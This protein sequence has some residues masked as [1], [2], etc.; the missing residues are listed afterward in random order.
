MA[1]WGLGLIAVIRGDSESAAEQY[2]RL[3]AWKDEFREYGRATFR[4]LGLMAALIGAYEEANSHFEEGYR[5]S[6][7]GGFLPNLARICSD[8]ADMLIQRGAAEDRI[9][10]K[11][12]LEEGLEITEKLGM[13]PLKERITGQLEKLDAKTTY[14]DGLTDREVQ[15][16]HLLPTGRTNQEIAAKLFISEKTV[17]N[18]ITNIFSKTGT[19]NRTEAAQYATKHDLTAD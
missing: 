19:S 3:M 17:A 12:L 10:A 8:R 15:I 6:K 16:L 11:K 13:K 5:L 9:G 2:E 4:T 1:R 7:E 14:P 18:H